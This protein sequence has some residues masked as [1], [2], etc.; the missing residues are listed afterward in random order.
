MLLACLPLS[1][2][3]PRLLLFSEL[4]TVVMGEGAGCKELEGPTS[5]GSN[6]VGDSIVL[7]PLTDPAMSDVASGFDW[8]EL[9]EDEVSSV[10]EGMKGVLSGVVVF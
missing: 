2:S 7:P 9:M 1:M 10:I 5:S 6:L 4:D 3:L 8:K